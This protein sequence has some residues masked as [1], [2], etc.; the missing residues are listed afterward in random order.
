MDIS[1]L[2]IMSVIVLAGIV[3]IIYSVN[4][5]EVQDEQF[6]QDAFAKPSGWKIG[7]MPPELQKTS[8]VTLKKVSG[9]SSHT[10]VDD[11]VERLK[12]KDISN[13]SKPGSQ[14]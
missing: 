14:K 4:T 9:H 11:L 1:V 13:I 3:Y 5:A 7:K 6:D 12:K 8:K 2:G 10:V